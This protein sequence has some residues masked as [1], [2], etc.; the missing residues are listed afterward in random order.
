M[1]APKTQ[2]YAS[3]ERW[4]IVASPYKCAVVTLHESLK[5]TV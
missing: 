4:D 5:I 2:F 1:R 3:G